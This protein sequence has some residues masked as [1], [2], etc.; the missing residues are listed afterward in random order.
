MATV[1]MVASN[2]VASNMVTSNMEGVRFS[3]ASQ[4]AGKTLHHRD[5]KAKEVYKTSGPV[6]IPLAFFCA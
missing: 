3:R 2:M 1:N 4:T 6:G 5:G